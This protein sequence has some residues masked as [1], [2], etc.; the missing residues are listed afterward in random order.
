MPKSPVSQHQNTAP[1]PPMEIAV[2]IP[3]MLPVPS[4]A[5]NAVA[6]DAKGEIPLAEDS[7]AERLKRIAFGNIFCIKPS[8]NVK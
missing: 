4:V 8:R 6:R 1:G 2:E 5:A 3:M 7:L